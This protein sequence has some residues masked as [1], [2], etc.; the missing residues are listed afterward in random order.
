MAFSL[1]LPSSLL[2]L[3]I[4]ITNRETNNVNFNFIVLLHYLHILLIDPIVTLLT[5]DVNTNRNTSCDSGESLLPFLRSDF[6][7]HKRTR[8]KM[9][10]EEQNVVNHF[11]M[12]MINKLLDFWV[13]KPLIAEMS[14]ANPVQ[15]R[16]KCSWPLFLVL[17]CNPRKKHAFY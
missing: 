6:P 17:G 16:V 11:K 3:P 1:P 12:K 7:F 5:K 14:E 13:L 2:K 10:Q 15:K 9:F 4:Y 8:Q